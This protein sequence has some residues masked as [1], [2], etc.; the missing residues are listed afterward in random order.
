MSL[1]HGEADGIIPF[2]EMHEQLLRT[3]LKVK[4][5]RSFPGCGHL[6]IVHARDEFFESLLD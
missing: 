4:E 2:A 3:G 5:I 1:W 6:F